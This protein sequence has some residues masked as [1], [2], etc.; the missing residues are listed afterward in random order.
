MGK[1]GLVGLI[2]AVPFESKRLVSGIKN[3]RASSRGITTGRIGGR[4]VAHVVSGMGITNAAHAA[5][6]LIEK[7]GPAIIIQFGIGGAYS[8]CGL[9]VGD[10]AVAESEAYADLG[11]F[12]DKGLEGIE[13]TGIPLVRKGRKKYFDT[14]PLDGKLARAALGA[15]CAPRA[16][17]GAFLTVSRVT[18]TRRR[19]GE[20]RRK[21]GAVCENM[22]G[23]AVAHVCALYGLPMVEIRGISNIV[24]ERDPG[25]WEKGLA[26]ENC[27][28]TVMEL[29]EKLP[30]TA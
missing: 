6:V 12:T 17:A 15:S 27:Q 30:E 14:F 11:V 18:G 2:S 24:G 4:R 26:S 5:T 7:H 29:L 21:Y 13:A 28:R 3:R 9:K 25:K 1:S 20:L 23:A 8:S 19:A 22:E 16:G 10:I